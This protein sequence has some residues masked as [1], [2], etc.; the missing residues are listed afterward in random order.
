M[1]MSKVV[2]RLM[3][4][5]ISATTTEKPQITV[6]MANS[7]G[8]FINLDYSFL[9]VAS[10]YATDLGE[11]IE[12]NEDNLKGFSHYKRDYN[13]MMTILENAMKAMNN[14]LRLTQDTRF[15]CDNLGASIFEDLSPILDKIKNAAML[16]IGKRW[17]NK[18]RGWKILDVVAMAEVTHML[19]G[20]KDES[21]K[22]ANKALSE[23]GFSARYANK[24][25]HLLDTHTATYM[26]RNLCDIFRK[27]SE[28]LN[29]ARCEMIALGMAEL[30]NKLNESDF[31]RKHYEKLGFEDIEQ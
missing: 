28:P 4:D 5:Y 8:A 14:T 27:G 18:S 15:R 29:L 31:M 2:Y 1:A 11:Q 6:D 23:I 21:E 19:L 13:Q 30:N 12:K 22:V 10:Y 24:I 26:A 17:T 25:T 3:P 7:F 16:E 20:V 9:S